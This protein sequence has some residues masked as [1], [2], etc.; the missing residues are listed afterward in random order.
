MTYEFEPPEPGVPPVSGRGSDGPPDPDGPVPFRT[1]WASFVVATAPTIQAKAEE[2]GSNSLASMGRLWARAQ[3]RS[4][5]DAEALE[6][7]C[8]LYAYGKMQR[9]MDAML[10]GK[11]PSEDTWHDLGVYATMAQ[12]IKQEGRWP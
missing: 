9:V 11:L 4:V 7:G 12:F 6:I 5:T 2:Y 3:G 8:A 10:V 1:W